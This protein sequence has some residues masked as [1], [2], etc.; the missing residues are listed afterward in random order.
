M[1]IANQITPVILFI[2]TL[3]LAVGAQLL[4]EW[5]VSFY[6]SFEVLQILGI[7]FLLMALVINV[8]AYKQFK[9]LETPDAPFQTPKQL[10]VSSVFKVSRNPVYFALL[11]SQVSL[12]FI[13][14]SIWILLSTLL[15]GY[16][17]DILIVRDEEKVLLKEFKDEYKSYKK[18]TNRWL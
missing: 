15:L 13:F 3:F 6:L 11:I 16:L 1:K 9:K 5:R 2:T 4:F 17:L 8:L 10:I 12:A 14:D 18:N 7:G